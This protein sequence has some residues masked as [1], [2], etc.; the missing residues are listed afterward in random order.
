MKTNAYCISS[1]NSLVEAVLAEQRRH[2][3]R[4]L[5]GLVDPLVAADEAVVHGDVVDGRVQ[6]H[7]HAVAQGQVGADGLLVGQVLVQVTER[8][9]ILNQH[10][11]SVSF[12]PHLICDCTPSSRAFSSERNRFSL[13]SSP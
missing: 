2:P 6:A 9:F 12:C 1:S 4:V 5:V 3:G 8:D 10:F 11:L 13:C 7:V